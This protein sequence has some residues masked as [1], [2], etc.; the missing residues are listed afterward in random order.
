VTECSGRGPP[1]HPNPPTHTAPPPPHPQ[2]TPTPPPPKEKTPNTPLPPPTNPT[3][4]PQ[5]P[6][7]LTNVFYCPPIR[8]IRLVI[9]FGAPQSVLIFFILCSVSLT[10]PCSLAYPIV[11]KFVSLPHELHTSVFL[12]P[13]V[14]NIA[15]PD[16]PAFVRL[17][18]PRVS[19]LRCAPC[20]V[21][22]CLVD[23]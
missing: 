7:G 8:Q 23:P 20:D 16:L 3:P 10:V 12:P 15:P 4:P 19:F 21:L 2:P 22:N 1:T 17:V 6:I 13:T 5:P 18:P 14:A 11:F 9:R